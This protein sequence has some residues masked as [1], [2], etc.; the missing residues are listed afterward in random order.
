M[1]DEL[2]HYKPI[3]EAFSL[4]LF[5]H[6]EVVIHDLKTGC[7][8]A[9]F[10]NFSKRAVGDESLLDEVKLL[11]HTQDIF[12]PY[13]KINWDGRKIKSV[14]AVLRNQRSEAIGLLCVNLD[15]SKWEEMHLF[16]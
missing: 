6:A 9:I 14:T 8:N 15:I 11:P 5:P 12:P 13:F 7:I 3:G 10:N 16:I 2:A 4:L 1:K